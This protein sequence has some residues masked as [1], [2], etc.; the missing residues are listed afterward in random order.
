[1]SI[2]INY[3]DGLLM[4]TLLRYSIKIDSFNEFRKSALKV[5]KSARKLADHEADRMHEYNIF[6]D[7]LT[8]LHATYDWSLSPELGGAFS[9]Y[10]HMW[11]RLG[12]LRTEMVCICLTTL[13]ASNLVS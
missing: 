2:P 11:K 1:M 9:S 10:G 5:I 7:N 8:H 12:E 13:A 4:L 3:L 6:A